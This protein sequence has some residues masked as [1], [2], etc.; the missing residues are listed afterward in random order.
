MRGIFGSHCESDAEVKE[1]KRKGR[2]MEE[3]SERDDDTNQL[4]NQ[5]TNEH[6]NK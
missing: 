2:E 3:K 6:C 1:I 5:L 4:G